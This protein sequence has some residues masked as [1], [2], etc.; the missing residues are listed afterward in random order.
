MKKTVTVDLDNKTINISIQDLLITDATSLSVIVEDIANNVKNALL[1]SEDYKAFAKS[2]SSRLL[3]TPTSQ[4][5]HP[6]GP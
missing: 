4:E 3:G 6:E 5:T 1:M 2:I